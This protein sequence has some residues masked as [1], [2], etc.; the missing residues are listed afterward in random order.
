MSF[1]DTFVKT[2]QRVLPSP[3]TIAVL[4]TGLTLALALTLTSPDPANTQNHFLQ[5]LGHWEG[6]FFTFLKFAMQMMLI[7]VLGHAL[8]LTKPANTLIQ[9]LVKYCTSTAKAAALVTF[10][11]IIVALFNWGLA[12]ILGAIFAR[13]VGEN[14]LKK[15]IP[16]N[17]PLIGAAGY[18]GLMV[19]HGG[20]SGSAPL[21]VAE[22][23]HDFVDQIGIVPVSQTIF[24]TMNVV[25]MVA[26]LLLVPLAMYWLGK[27]VSPTPIDIKLDQNNFNNNTSVAPEGAEKLDHARWL[28]WLLGGTM[29]FI[30]I[31]KVF[32]FP[33]WSGNGFDWSFRFI[34]PN[35]II[36]LLFALAVLLHGSFHRFNQSIAQGIGG[37]T[38]IMIQFPLYAGIMGIMSGSGLATIFS[39]AFVDISS[40]TTFPIFTFFSAGLV[41]IFVPSGG[42]QW[43]V[44]A[45]VL[46][47]AS[48]ELNLPIA[49]SI[50]AL[51]Y[52]DQV[53]NMLQPFWALPLLGITG[54]QA[55]E[56]LP[57]TLFLLLT[58]ICIFCTILL[59]F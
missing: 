21:I 22:E 49:K 24:S 45:P 13:K 19:W 18:T 36:F 54:L 53:T 52:G 50:M 58:G 23:G 37:S 8:A 4:L 55:K 42:G 44:Q 34:N 7:L 10:T 47:Q 33:V 31:Y 6:G 56:I 11:S 41:N 43:V 9:S 39:N 38:G 29:L 32:I 16:L 57:Y 27:R 5:L 12:L 28:A 48:Q 3:F 59:L 25:C 14:A 26:L 15:N 46:I 2:A 20:L 1:A 17:Y 51:S 35:Y 30:A 40:S